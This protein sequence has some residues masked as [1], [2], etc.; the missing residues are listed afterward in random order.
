MNAIFLDYVQE[1]MRLLMTE[2]FEDPTSFVEEMQMIPI[3]PDLSSQFE[4]TP[5]EE[6]VARHASRFSRETV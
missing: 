5:K 3:P 1:L 6:L 2:V 4:R